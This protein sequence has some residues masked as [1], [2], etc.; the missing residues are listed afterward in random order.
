MTCNFQQKERIG[1]QMQKDSIQGN[2]QL[3]EV[4]ANTS[5]VEKYLLLL[6]AVAPFDMNCDYQIHQYYKGYEL[7]LAYGNK[8]FGKF[9][10]EQNKMMVSLYMSEQKNSQLNQIEQLMQNS[11][12]LAV[13]V[14]FFSLWIQQEGFYWLN[15]GVHECPA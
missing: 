4:V 12:V 14:R 8:Y 7:D 5:L 2:M 1:I 15:S 10:I 11:L 9:Q 3:V 13:E 6:A